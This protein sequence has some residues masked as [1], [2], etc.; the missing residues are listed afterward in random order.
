M[1]EV[2]RNGKGGLHPA[3][4]DRNGVSARDPLLRLKNGSARDDAGEEGACQNSHR[5]HS[6]VNFCLE[7]SSRFYTKM[8]YTVTV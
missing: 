5:A 6:M 1:K 8:V 3:A 2:R 4:S 7:I